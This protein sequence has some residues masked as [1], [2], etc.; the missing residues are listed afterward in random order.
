VAG[1]LLKTGWGVGR[2]GRCWDRY[3][4]NG[5]GSEGRRVGLQIWANSSQRSGRERERELAPTEISPPQPLPCEKRG[6][7]G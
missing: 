3:R 4:L 1:L 2:G 6:G 5:K 7:K